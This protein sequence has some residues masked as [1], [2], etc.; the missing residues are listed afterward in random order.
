MKEVGAK[1]DA[2]VDS[3][4]K[5]VDVAGQQ[6]ERNLRRTHA[7]NEELVRLRHEE[8][9]LKERCSYLEEVLSDTA[10]QLDRVCDSSL[11]GLL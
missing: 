9:V 8:R 10:I 2:L 7:Q 3:T 6:I 1:G 11:F 5:K 4:L